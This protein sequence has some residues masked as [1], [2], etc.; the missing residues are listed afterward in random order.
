MSYYMKH[1]LNKIFFFIRRSPHL[2]RG[3][4]IDK[5]SRVDENSHIGM[6]TYLGRRCKVTKAQIGNYC[7]IGDNVTIG[8]GEHDIMDI[9]TSHIFF[10]ERDWYGELT[11]N[12]CIIENDVWIGVNA[13]IRR[14]VTVAHGAVIGANSYV[15]K[16]V[17]PFAV[18]VGSP[19]KIIKYRFPFELQQKIIASQWWDEDVPRA[20]EILTTLRKEK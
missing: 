17:P 16:N 3:T 14:G 4:F 12:E 8:P 15:N 13:V 7:S 11:K 10:E 19:A 20:K 6:N 9:S 18:V 2:G 5:T 1:I